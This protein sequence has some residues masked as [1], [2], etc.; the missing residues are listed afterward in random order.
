MAG[1]AVVLARAKRIPRDMPIV[2]HCSPGRGCTTR[3]AK[4]A[5]DAAAKAT[6]VVKH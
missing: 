6:G 4:N 3:N 1:A 2:P 5:F